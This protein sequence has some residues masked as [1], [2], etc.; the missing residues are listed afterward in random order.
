MKKAEKLPQGVFRDFCFSLLV[1]LLRDFD[2]ALSGGFFDGLAVFVLVT[3]PH[4]VPRRHAWAGGC[5]V[6]AIQ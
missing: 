1:N 6:F 2:S 3:Y 4:D 5:T